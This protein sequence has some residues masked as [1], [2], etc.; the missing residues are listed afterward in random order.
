MAGKNRPESIHVGRG[1]P[2]CLVNLPVLVKKQK[3]RDW[4]RNLKNKVVVHA[5]SRRYPP[6]GTKLNHTVIVYLP[7]RKYFAPVS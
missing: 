5:E 3:V 2:R 4:F 6:P 1:V 7:H